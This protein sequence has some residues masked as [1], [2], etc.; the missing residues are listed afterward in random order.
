M[1]KSEAIKQLHIFI[2][3]P[4]NYNEDGEHFMSA[5]A[6]MDFVMN[7]LKMQPPKRDYIEHYAWKSDNSWE[8]E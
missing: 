2:H 8:K 7:Q 4:K 5:E 1:K 3:D 6:I